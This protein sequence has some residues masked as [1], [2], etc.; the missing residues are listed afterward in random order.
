M[1]GAMLRRV[2]AIGLI[3]VWE[4]IFVCLPLMIACCR[5]NHEER[6]R[7]LGSLVV[8]CVTRLGPCFVKV[9]QMFSYRSDL[10]SPNFLAPM[11]HLQDDVRYGARDDDVAVCLNLLGG[12]GL[13]IDVDPLP[14]GAGSVALVFKGRLGNG[15]VVAVKVVRPWVAVAIERD[16]ALLRRLIALVARLPSLKSVPLLQL[17]DEVT[18]LVAR[19]V[20]MIFEGDVLDAFLALALPNASVDMPRR[21][22]SVDRH[23]GILVMTWAGDSLR[24]CA[25]ALSEQDFRLAGLELLRRL[26]RMIFLEGL[27]HCD[28]HPGNVLSRGGANLTLIDLGLAARLSELDRTNFRAFF[29][30][31]VSND[32]TG[33]AAAIIRSARVQPDLIDRIRLRRDVSVLL[34]THHGRKAGEFLVAQFVADVFDL[35]RRHEL[36]GAP[37]FVSAIWALVMYEGLIRDKYPDLDFQAEASPYVISHWISQARV[38]NRLQPALVISGV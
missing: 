17:F 18:K 6:D 3:V 20:D 12:C 7:L 38:G 36:Y 8:K 14:S 28:L 5:R 23:P 4:F 11:A 37:G 13:G 32:V 15:E 34:A 22:Q 31:F 19:Q 1:S 26:Y 25:A 10:L 2:L 21:I 24:Y 29:A 35:Q 33:C 9:A 27:V 16:N 30:A